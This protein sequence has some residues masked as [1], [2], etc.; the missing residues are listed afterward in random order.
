MA[1]HTTKQYSI[2]QIALNLTATCFISG[3]IIAG[4]YAVTNPIAVKQAA[5]SQTNAMKSLV[6]TAD[7]FKTISGKTGW[8][9]ATQGGKLIAYV[10][11]GETKGYGGTIKM[12]VAITPE[13]KVIN[14]DILSA[15]ET[16]GLGDKAAK[17][18][19]KK[20]FVGKGAEDLI[21]TKD[22]SN[23]KNIQSMT[24]A[25][26]SSKAVTKGVKEAVEEVVQFVGGK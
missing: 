14:Y 22:P 4:T 3:A 21:V 25:T 18:P 1:E 24:G 26:I 9:E 10:I 12:L 20:Q 2:L 15:N 6:Q 11:P 19:F 8:Y 23:T 13:G 7:D 17:E 16:Q 5:I